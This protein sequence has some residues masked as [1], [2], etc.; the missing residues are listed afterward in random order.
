LTDIKL[1]QKIISCAAYILMTLVLTARSAIPSHFVFYI[2]MGIVL[3]FSDKIINNE[4]VKHCTAVAFF[5]FATCYQT[6]YQLFT[7]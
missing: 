4:K 1:K 6:F 2:C 5:V 3:F 7:D